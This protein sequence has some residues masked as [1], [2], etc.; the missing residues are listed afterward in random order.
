MNAT[1]PQTTPFPGPARRP[2]P[3]SWGWFVAAFAG[4]AT[5]LLL[6]VVVCV[7]SFLPGSELRA[8]R[9]AVHAADPAGWQRRIEVGAGWLPVWVVRTGSSFV[10]LPAEARAALDSVRSAD[11]GIYQRTSRGTDETAAQLHERMLTTMAARGWEPAVTVRDG[12][13]VVTVFVPDRSPRRPTEL[14]AAVAVIDGDDLVLATA[15]TD[16]APMVDWLARK[17]GPGF[18]MFQ[19]ARR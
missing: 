12:S 10:D 16:L 18:P 15:N 17:H 19:L 5:L 2:H 14:K 11:V 4:L 8:L 7:A 6:A 13:Q 3:R 9:N 1:P